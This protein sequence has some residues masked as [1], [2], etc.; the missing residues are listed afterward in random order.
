MQLVSTSGRAWWT[1]WTIGLVSYFVGVALVGSIPGNQAALG[2]ALSISWPILAYV[3][4]RKSSKEI[5]QSPMVL[6]ATTLMLIAVVGRWFPSTFTAVVFVIILIPGVIAA[7]IAR[8]VRS[9]RARRSAAVSVQAEDG[10]SDSTPEPSAKPSGLNWKS[11]PLR[12]GVAIPAAIILLIAVSA[13]MSTKSH[14]TPATANDC[15]EAVAPTVEYLAT[16][17]NQIIY[18][19]ATDI[20]FAKVSGSIGTLTPSL[21]GADLRRS[22]QLLSAWTKAT[23][24][25]W[26]DEGVHA[27]KSTLGEA[28]DAF[29]AAGDDTAALTK[30]NEAM[31][32][33]RALAVE[34]NKYA[35][36]IRLGTPFKSE[37]EHAEVEPEVPRG[38]AA[39][40]VN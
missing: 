36:S 6:W 18:A 25:C 1:W 14:D 7:L 22:E 23:E 5:W 34:G 4:S 2:G 38:P 16:V 29:I 11:W 17:N 8:A 21:Y 3:G 37:G 10:Q 19:F 20:E 26:N 31:F 13:S 24:S 33:L 30:S 12:L 39:T 9:H 35:T 27:L 15:G 32:R 28:T 40:A